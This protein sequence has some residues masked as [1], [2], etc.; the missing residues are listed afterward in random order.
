M[1][2]DRSPS[3]SATA[4]RTPPAAPSSGARCRS[5]R[6]SPRAIARFVQELQQPRRS[7]F[8]RLA[9]GQN[10]PVFG[11]RQAFFQIPGGGGRVRGVAARNDERGNLRAQHVL[12]LGA[13]RGVAVEERAAHIGGELFVLFGVQLRV[14]VGKRA[15][16]L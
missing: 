1:R 6:S 7:G 9:V 12:G 13:R 14:G 3:S 4:R 11:T 16:I 5:G 10:V 15:V 2:R 8:L